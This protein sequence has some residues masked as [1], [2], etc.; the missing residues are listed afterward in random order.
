MCEPLIYAPH[1][2][3]FWFLMEGGFCIKQQLFSNHHRASKNPKNMGINV[4]RNTN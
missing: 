1:P 3:A 4:K 2:F